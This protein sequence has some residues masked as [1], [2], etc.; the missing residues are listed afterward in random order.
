MA[1]LEQLFPD[2]DLQG[3]FR[4]TVANLAGDDDALGSVI[5]DIAMHGAISSTTGV[6][7]SA[8]FGLGEAF[9]L[10]SNKG[11]TPDTIF[12]APGSLFSRFREGINAATTEPPDLN[13]KAVQR[14]VPTAW[15]NILK[16]A[17]DGGK[18]RKANGALIY[19][20]D[21]WEKIQLAIGF[22]PVVLNRAREAAQLEVRASDRQSR[23][24]R[25]FYAAASDL[26]NKG[27]FQGVQDLIL[28]RGRADS[29]Q[30]IQSMGREIVR[31]AQEKR[32]PQDPGKSGLRAS[33]GDRERIRSMFSSFKI[34][35]PSEA[36]QYVERKLDE[37][38][39]GIPGL[40]RISARELTKVQVVD[41]L[42]ALNPGLSSQR[43]R[44]MVDFRMGSN[45]LAPSG[46]IQQ[47]Q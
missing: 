3:T 29:T 34:P 10:D 2:L 5:S 45:P 13:G 12:G 30:S 35:T 44:M 33:I 42:I 4:E 23:D 28:E 8:R 32:I 7:L 27:G 15:S 24:Q 1:I 22:K 40:G 17:N 47:D 20:P 36:S 25:K 38:Q 26:F 46:Q 21:T 41:R 39:L 19:N 18:V 9:G 31:L 6:D 14:L 16:L 37:R 43:L 11:F